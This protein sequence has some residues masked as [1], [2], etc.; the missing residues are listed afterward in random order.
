M[1]EQPHQIYRWIKEVGTALSIS[2]AYRGNEVITTTTDMVSGMILSVER[3]VLPEC[4]DQECIELRGRYN[5]STG[6]RLN[7]IADCYA[8]NAIGDHWR[9]YDFGTYG[10]D[11]SCYE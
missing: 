2:T 3:V 5:L 9:W 7:D 6:E 4:T 8:P 1:D 11:M 10:G